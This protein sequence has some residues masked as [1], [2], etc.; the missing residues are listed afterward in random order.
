MVIRP[1]ELRCP[2]ADLLPTRQAALSSANIYALVRNEGNQSLAKTNC[3][4]VGKLCHL[5]W[6]MSRDRH[7]GELRH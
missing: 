2:G 5:Y 3:P 1:V 6:K 7:C 4:K